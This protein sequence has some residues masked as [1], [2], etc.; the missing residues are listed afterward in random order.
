MMKAIAV[1]EVGFETPIT[2][3]QHQLMA[4]EPLTDGGTDKGPAPMMLLASALASC[5]AITTRMYAGRKQWPLQKV[6]VE[7]LVEKDGINSRFSRVVRF[8]GPLDTEQQARLQ[9]IANR[10]PVH[11][12]LSAANSIETSF[13]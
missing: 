6:E 11:R 13:Q 1:N 7:V 12:V 8:T 9:D 4:D 10:C 5:T 2:V 3:N